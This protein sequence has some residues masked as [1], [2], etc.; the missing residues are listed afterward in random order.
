MDP[1]RVK[2]HSGKIVLP[3]NVK[4]GL[5]PK[6]AIKLADTEYYQ[7]AAHGDYVQEGMK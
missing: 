7:V 3:T 1:F 4:G 2:K 6:T 5:T